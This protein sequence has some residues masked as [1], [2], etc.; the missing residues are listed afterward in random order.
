MAT[1]DAV[2]TKQPAVAEIHRPRRRL[3]RIITG[4]IVPRIILIPAAALFIIPFYWMLVSA[5]KSTAELTKFPPTLI[6]GAWVWSNFIDAVNYIPFG[7]YAFN[8]FV[9]TLGVTIGSVLSN[10][11][12]AY[13]FHGSSGR[14]GT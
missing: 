7:L 10:T 8:S 4:S 2:D 11:V 14:A 12:V 5:L 6:P 3:G 9:I 13:G 1:T